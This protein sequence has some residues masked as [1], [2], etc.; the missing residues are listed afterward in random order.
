MMRLITA[1]GYVYCFALGVGALA[2]VC[3]FNVQSTCDCKLTKQIQL[4][5]LKNAHNEP[6]LIICTRMFYMQ[7]RVA[8][9]SET[10]LFSTARMRET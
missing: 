8:A 1:H 7:V 5:N 9:L 2:A 4:K 6:N 10:Y 3:W